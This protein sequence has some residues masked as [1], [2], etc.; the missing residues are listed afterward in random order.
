MFPNKI[1]VV[2]HSSAL[3]GNSNILITQWIYMHISHNM[4]VAHSLDILIPIFISLDRL[5]YRPARPIGPENE[6]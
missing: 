1:H 5:G 2:Y 6:P 3:S 4:P